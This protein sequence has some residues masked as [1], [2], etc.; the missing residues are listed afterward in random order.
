MTKDPNCDAVEG[1]EVAGPIMPYIDRPRPGTGLAGKFFD[2]FTKKR[3]LWKCVPSMRS[4][5][6]T[7]AGL[8]LE[9]LLAMDPADGGPLDDNPF[10]QLVIRRWVFE[11]YQACGTAMRAA[12]RNGGRAFWRA[13]RIRLRR[14][15]SR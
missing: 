14:H 1:V 13:F 6:P 15:S 7:V 3:G 8:N 2:A 11:Q 5:R 9:Q 4:I 12:R 10:R